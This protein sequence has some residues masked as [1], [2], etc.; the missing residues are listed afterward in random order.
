MNDSTMQLPEGKHCSDC[1]HYSYCVK[2]FKCLPTNIECDFSPSK[3]FAKSVESSFIGTITRL[4]YTFLFDD[5]GITIK[6]INYQANEFTL[7]SELEKTIY[8]HLKK[9]YEE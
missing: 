5:N 7:D 9:K 3:F 8:D 6:T 1:V 4:D 2:L